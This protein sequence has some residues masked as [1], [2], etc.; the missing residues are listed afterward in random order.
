QLAPV[1]PFFRH[2]IASELLRE[3]DAAPD[4]ARR[5]RLTRDAVA[6]LELSL[7]TGVHQEFAHFNL[8][9]LQLDL[10]QPA[11]AA[12]HFIAAARLVPDKG[13]VYFGLGIALP[14]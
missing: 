8:G 1:D 14:P 12:H 11:L 3:R 6:Q 10:N 13:G 4:P 5:L 9:W 2:Q 7:A